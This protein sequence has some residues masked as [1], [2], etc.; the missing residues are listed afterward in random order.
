[1]FLGSDGS[2]NDIADIPE[3]DIGNGLVIKYGNA[4]IKALKTE[5]YQKQFHQKHNRTA[6][7]GNLK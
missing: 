6:G 2:W 1:M 5:S 4:M 3:G 7:Y